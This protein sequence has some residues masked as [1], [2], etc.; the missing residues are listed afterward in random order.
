MPRGCL[1]ANGPL[2]FVSISDPSNDHSGNDVEST[3]SP[4]SDDEG[5]GDDGDDGDDDDDFD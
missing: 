4:R 5:K 3:L 2:V 1:E